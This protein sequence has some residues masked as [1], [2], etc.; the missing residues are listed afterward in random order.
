MDAAPNI[1]FSECNPNPISID[2]P[3]TPLFPSTSPPDLNLNPNPLLQSP[4]LLFLQ[5]PV[6]LLLLL[7]LAIETLLHHFPTPTY[8]PYTNTNPTNPHNDLFEY[9]SSHTNY[10]VFFITS[11]LLFQSYHTPEG[12][13]ALVRFDVLCVLVA[14][15]GIVLGG[16][17]YGGWDKRG[18]VTVRGAGIKKYLSAAISSILNPNPKTEAKAEDM[19]ID[20][21]V[22]E[23][24]QPPTHK[25][26]P[27]TTLVAD[28]VNIQVGKPIQKVGQS[29]SRSR[30]GKVGGG[31]KLAGRVARITR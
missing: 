25:P 27:E 31:R 17:R 5:T 29:G 28:T 19:Q 2:E 30:V 7:T 8:T 21:P 12:E 20:V 1:N 14:C 9:I 23:L 3:L 10:P 13:T 4:F 15:M 6:I 11:L 22:Q 16:L 24:P 18:C 26:K